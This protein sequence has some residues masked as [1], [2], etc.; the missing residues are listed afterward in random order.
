MDSVYKREA[1][2]VFNIL[3]DTEIGEGIDLSDERTKIFNEY[4]SVPLSSLK[5][6]GECSATKAALDIASSIE[7]IKKYL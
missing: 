3:K 6:T 7:R 5:P 1:E 2:V 4:L